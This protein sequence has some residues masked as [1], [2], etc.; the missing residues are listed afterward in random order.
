MSMTIAI[1]C[2][3]CQRTGVSGVDYPAHPHRA[4]LGAAGWA[5]GCASAAPSRCRRASVETGG[6][7]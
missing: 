1:R 3:G 6:Q 7:G 4:G 5:V 2:D